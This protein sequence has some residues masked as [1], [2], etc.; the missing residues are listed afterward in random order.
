MTT[1]ANELYGS[2]KRQ[3]SII[4]P[5][6]NE[7]DHLEESVQSILTQDYLGDIEIILAIAPSQ[8][9]TEKIAHALAEKDSRI[10]LVENCN[11]SYKVFNHCPRRWPFTNTKELL[12]FSLGNS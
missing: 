8:D 12:D 6:L 7:A 3:I 9:E 10:V 1:S 4:L 11:C 5:V 2:P